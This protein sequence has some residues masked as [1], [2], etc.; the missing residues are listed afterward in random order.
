MS[1]PLESRRTLIGCHSA[2]VSTNEIPGQFASISAIVETYRI[3]WAEFISADPWIAKLDELWIAHEDKIP[4]P[5]QAQAM[6]ALSVVVFRPTYP[7]LIDLLAARSRVALS[8]SSNSRDA[9]LI[10]QGLLQYCLC[11]GD[12]LAGSAVLEHVAQKVDLASVDPIHAIGWHTTKINFYAALLADFDAANASFATAEKLVQSSGV[13]VLNSLL[14]GNAAHAAIATGDLALATK[15]LQIMKGA[16]PPFQLL[17]VSFHHYLS[18]IVELHRNNP[19]E[20]RDL[21]GK[22]LN[23]SEQLGLEFPS[24]FNALALACAHIEL[25]NTDEAATYFDRILEVFRRGGSLQLEWVTLC[26]MAYADIKAGRL[27]NIQSDLRKWLAI[28]REHNYLTHYPCLPKV[29]ETVC[30]LALEHGIEVQHVKRIV[31]ANRLLPPSP[32]TTNW[33]WP[34]KIRVLGNF[35]IE[36]DGARVQFGRKS[37]KKDLALL[38]LLIAGGDKGLAEAALKDELWPE[39]DGDL[40]SNNL[41]QSI[42][43]LR[44]LLQSHQAI[45]SKNGL[46]TLDRK[47]IWGDAWSLESLCK[48]G[49]RL[50]GDAS[51]LGDYGRRLVELYQ[52]NFVVDG[53]DLPSLVSYREQLRGL[54]VERVTLV[55]RHMENAGDH[56]AALEL[57]RE[58]TKVDNYFEA[59][60]QGQMRCLRQLNRHAEGLAIFDRLRQVMLSQWKTEPSKLSNSIAEEL[61]RGL[62]N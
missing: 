21:A 34:I 15:L 29:Q 55:T 56:G 54:F 57:Y 20:A 61:R 59:F 62:S 39:S 43:R 40:A 36:L 49:S 44:A 35:S 51:S 27:T 60:Y 18:A 25:G 30:A 9:I 13:I 58:A 48:E 31:R 14:Y 32:D 7:R 11:K 6:L 10:G 23:I 8:Q 1:D 46:L 17:N 3:A 38:K 47:L 41:K 45:E 16:V 2:F 26:L 4:Q 50:N 19:H 22:A 53:M 33:P 5:L 37:P 12:I 28:A 52:G 42:H 24:A